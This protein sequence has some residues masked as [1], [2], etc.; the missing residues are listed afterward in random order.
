MRLP[1]D[2]ITG[3]TGRGRARWVTRWMP[4]LNAIF[5]ANN[6]MTLGAMEA[7]IELGL[8]PADVPLVSFDDLPWGADRDHTVSSIGQPVYDMGRA[9]ASMVL[10]RVH[11][12]DGPARDIQLPLQLAEDKLKGRIPTAALPRFTETATSGSRQGS[13]ATGDHPVGASTSARV[14][15][16]PRTDPA[17][18][19]SAASHV[20]A[21]VTD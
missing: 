8:T 11:G 3:P 10:E 4:A 2:P 12:F 13:D 5:V 17:Q 18:P 7:L 9:A 20:P 6:L 15:A 16:H 19:K 21:P 14:S 1:G